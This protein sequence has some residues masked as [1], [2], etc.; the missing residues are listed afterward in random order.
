MAVGI[1][2]RWRSHRADDEGEMNLPNM[3]SILRLVS[4]PGIVWLLLISEWQGAFLLFCLAGISDAVDGFIARVFD[5]RTLLGGF[6]DPIADKTLL[7]AIYLTLGV[8]EILPGWLVILVV[9][10]DLMIVGGVLLL[11][12]LDQ[13]LEMAPIPSSKLNTAAQIALAAL[14]IAILAFEL[15]EYDYVVQGLI[16]LTAATAAISGA[17]YI[18]EWTRRFTNSEGSTS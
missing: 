15:S 9:S 4:T 5:S 11:Y 18:I 7:V 12:T 6:L 17:I 13:K 3:I 2:R 10:R 14:S 16:I 8:Q 1:C